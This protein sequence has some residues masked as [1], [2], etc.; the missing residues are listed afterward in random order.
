MDEL[1]TRVKGLVGAERLPSL[2]HVVS[3]WLIRNPFQLEGVSAEDVDQEK[4]EEGVP[5]TSR[6][7]SRHLLHQL[8][9]WLDA[10]PKSKPLPP[11]M[12]AEEEPVRKPFDVKQRLLDLERDLFPSF[13][14]EKSS[15]SN[16]PEESM[17]AGDKEGREGMDAQGARKHG[18]RFQWR[19]DRERFKT[20]GCIAGAIMIVGIVIVFYY[21]AGGESISQVDHSISTSNNRTP[22][23]DEE[24]S[25]P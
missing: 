19:W 8:D 13:T 22:L 9:A 2:D 17:E 11:K 23:Q 25:S 16:R 1:R 3:D 5:N 12:E 21:V 24:K 7:E 10:R 20:I 6:S 14:A 15:M 18:T 4:G